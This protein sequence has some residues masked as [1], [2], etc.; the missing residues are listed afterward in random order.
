MPFDK[1]KALE[2]AE[3]PAPVT[4]LELVQISEPEKPRETLKVFSGDDR[5]SDAAA[6]YASERFAKRWPLLR[7]DWY[8]SSGGPFAAD[9]I[10]SLAGP[11]T[12]QWAAGRIL[13][14]LKLLE[15]PTYK[16]VL[17]K[18]LYEPLYDRRKAAFVGRDNYGKEID[19]CSI[20]QLRDKL[21]ARIAELG[22]DPDL[23]ELYSSEHHTRTFEENEVFRQLRF[24]LKMKRF[25]KKPGENQ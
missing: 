7:N 11:C 1:N 13:F 6:A 25:E 9:Y 18:Y 8:G 22:L 24:D 12:S 21:N 23:I 10:K 4:T 17:Y 3:A 16:A 20:F 5:F 15:E 14:Q 19:L 2:I